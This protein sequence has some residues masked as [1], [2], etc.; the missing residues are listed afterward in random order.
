[1]TV[2]YI[3]T[4][5][6]RTCFYPKWLASILSELQEHEKTPRSLT[7]NSWGRHVIE[8]PQTPHIHQNNTVIQPVELRAQSA[9]GGSLTAVQTQ[10][11]NTRSAQLSLDSNRGSAL[12]VYIRN[13]T[14]TKSSV[15]NNTKKTFFFTRPS[16]HFHD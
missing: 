14:Q 1:M 6:F 3:S 16:S 5:A 12:S 10:T 11:D 2:H 13:T 9:G 4:G 8:R 7:P 15:T